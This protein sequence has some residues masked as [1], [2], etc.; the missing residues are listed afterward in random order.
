[1]GT[2]LHGDYGGKCY[3]HSTLFIDFSKIFDFIHRGKIEQIIHIYGLI[4]ETL[5]ALRM[6]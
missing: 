3:Y 2:S 5:T 1:M 4:K 6:L